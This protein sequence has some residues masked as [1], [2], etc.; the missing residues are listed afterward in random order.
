M[1]LTIS[2]KPSNIQN[3]K[4]LKM[5]IKLRNVSLGVE[6]PGDPTL[7]CVTYIPEGKSGTCN[8]EA[9]FHD[10]KPSDFSLTWPG[11]SDTPSLQL[12]N[13]KREDNGTVFTC[14]MIWNGH[15]R[16]A[17]YTLQVVCEYSC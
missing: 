1:L 5:L 15:R 17:N 4:F 12:T 7:P 3:T 16:T 14:L 9:R 2:L 8:C 11:H 6:P 13:V 10:D